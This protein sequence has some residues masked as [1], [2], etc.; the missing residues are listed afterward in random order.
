M[1]FDR[2]A[3]LKEQDRI[4]GIIREKETKIMESGLV[5]DEGWLKERG[6]V[7]LALVH[8]RG[9]ADRATY[10]SYRTREMLPSIIYRPEHIHTTLCTNGFHQPFKFNG[11]HQNWVNIF[12][13]AAR[14]VVEKRAWNPYVRYNEW[15]YGDSSAIAPGQ[16]ND[17]ALDLLREIEFTL[18]RAG[19]QDFKLAWGFGITFTRFKTPIRGVEAWPK[20]DN[21]KKEVEPILESRPVGIAVGYSDWSDRFFNGHFKAVERYPF[22]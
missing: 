3:F 11:F 15:I 13:D 16:P 4:Y 21:L 10:M 8:S 2:E 6:T 1:S 20:I 17:E 9:A 22:E 18:A 19:A 5:T 12:R 7:S 14:I